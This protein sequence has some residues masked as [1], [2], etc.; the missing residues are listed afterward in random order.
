MLVGCLLKGYVKRRFNTVPQEELTDYKEYLH[1]TLLRAGST[2]YAI[3]ICFDH[4]MFAK[5]P[6]EADDRLGGVP[7]PVSFFY[8]DRDWMMREGGEHVVAK[9]PYRGTHSHVHIVEDSDHHMYF[10]NPTDFAEKILLDLEN[11]DELDNERELRHLD[12]ME[13]IE[14]EEPSEKIILEDVMVIA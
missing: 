8:G 1:Q 6:L 5:H 2:E 14:N 10:D 9:N 11:L 4:L 3:F 12:E 7:I 13:N